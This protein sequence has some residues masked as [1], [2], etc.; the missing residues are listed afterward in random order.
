[1][2][3]PM[4]ADAAHK[5]QTVPLQS[6]AYIYEPKF[7][8][9]RAIVA[10][11]YKA[12]APTA[13]IFARSG[14]NKT[15]SFP[16]IMMG[17]ADLCGQVHK[18][19]IL[20]GEIV[21]IN[22]QGKPTSFQNIQT[23][24]H[25]K[26]DAAARAKT[27]RCA[28]MAFDLLELDGVNLR[29]EPLGKRKIALATLLHQQDDTTI[30]FGE[31][32]AGDGRE[33]FTRAKAEGWEGLIAKDIHSL[34]REGKRTREWIKLKFV[35]RQEFVVGGWT[36]PRLSRQHLGSLILGIYEQGKLVYCGNAGTGFTQKELVR[37]HALLSA[38]ESKKSPFA[39][40]PKT[41]EKAH[42]VQPH[43]LAE[44]KYCETTDDGKLRFP[45]YIGLR[46]DKNPRDVVWENKP[47]FWR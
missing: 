25:V 11:E 29:K 18:S 36:E 23:R 42:W 40:P 24:M 34:Y 22:A 8:G 41:N 43:Y 20:D 4:L 31:V 47:Q 19:F 46:D 2:I 32:A 10:C 16:D 44:V 28:L 33:M 35:T 1:M 37:V 3:K 39:T 14:A 30:K 38:I 15:D 7:D 12:G 13:Q 9:M 27:N 5:D 6:T 45:V 21:A 17:A 26:S